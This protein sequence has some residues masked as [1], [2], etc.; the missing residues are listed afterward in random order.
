MRQANCGRVIALGFFDGVHLGHGALLRRVAQ[1]AERTGAVPSACTFDTHPGDVI[2]KSPMP[3]LSTPEDRAWLMRRCYQ[4]Q[5][6]IVAPFDEHMM[7]MPWRAFVTDYLVGQWGAVHLVAGHDFHFGYKG[8]GS[9]ERLEGLCRELGLG[10]DIVPKVEREHITI[11][12][13]YIRTLVAQGEL[14][15][16]AEFLGHPHTLGVRLIPAEAGRLRLAVPR[17][18]LLPGPGRYAG[19]LL[20]EQGAPL[21][22]EVAVSETGAAVCPQASAVPAGELRLEWLGRIGAA[23]DGRGGGCCD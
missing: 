7:H 14:E 9:P 8:E 3:L 19:R 18:V 21:P 13:T 11:S 23:P 15:R 17:N 20:P 2:L 1:A 22:V 6:V 16:A 5:D 12:S 4:I 10:C